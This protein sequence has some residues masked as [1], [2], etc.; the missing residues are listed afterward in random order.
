MT[1]ILQIPA[2]Q[3][4]LPGARTYVCDQGTSIVLFNVEG[5]LYAIDD[6]CPHS[7]AS[8]SGGKL[9][10]LTLQCPAH[11]LKFNIATGCLRGGGRMRARSYTVTRVD[12][13]INI[14]PDVITSEEKDK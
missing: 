8:L 11:G 3:A 1:R 12:G 14:R 7:G 5:N 6:S 9:D 13:I 2:S 4:P 10:G